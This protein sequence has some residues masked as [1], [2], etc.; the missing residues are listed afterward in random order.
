MSASDLFARA[1]AEL[2]ETGRA[3]LLAPARPLY[4][5]EADAVPG[6]SPLAPLPRPDGA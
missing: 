4:L 5:R 2:F 6:H 3:H 1:A